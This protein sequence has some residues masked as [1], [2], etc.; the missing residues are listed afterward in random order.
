MGWQTNSSRVVYENP[1]IRVEDRDVINPA[2]NPAKYGVIHFKNKA[3]GVIALDHQRNIYLVGQ[4]RYALDQ[5]SWEIPEGGCPEG[6]LLLDAAK[7]EL[8]EETGLRA[9]T[10]QALFTM[11]LSNSVSDEQAHIYLA[12][13]LSQGIQNLEESEDISVKKISLDKALQMI[14]QGEITDAITIAAL[15]KIERLLLIEA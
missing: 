3:I 4:S 9:Q 7:R 11:H 10:W 12:T 8:A 13:E 15:L 6:E 2:G 1:W 5:Y 14:D